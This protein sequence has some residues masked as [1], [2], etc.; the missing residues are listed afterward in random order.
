MKG[1]TVTQPTCPRCAVELTAEIVGALAL[2]R[3]ASCRGVWLDPETFRLLCEADAK[4]REGRAAEAAA[5]G[6]LHSSRREDRV[7]YLRCPVCNDLMSRVNFARVSGVILDVCRPHGAWFD[8]GELRAVRSFVRGSGLSR[9]KRR[10]ELDIERERRRSARVSSGSGASGVDLIDELAGIPNRWDVPSR[11]TPARGFLRAGVLA[12]I[13]GA[14][15]WNA[16]HAYSPRGAAGGVI[17]G[18][19]ALLAAYRAFDHALARRRAQRD[20]VT[21]NRRQRRDS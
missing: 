12:I 2:H 21:P 16:F 11:K 5:S 10:R 8:A 17:V 3:C 4:A 1:A 18:C 15:L 6:Y 9:F 14:V 7:Q 19:I 20:A 13:G